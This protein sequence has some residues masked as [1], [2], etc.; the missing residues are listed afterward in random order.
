[1]SERKPGFKNKIGRPNMNIV[2]GVA[3]NAEGDATFEREDSMTGKIETKAAAATIA[4]GVRRVGGVN[5]YF[6][7]WLAVGMP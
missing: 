5:D 3:A 6:L 1:M 7:L 4:D 2:D